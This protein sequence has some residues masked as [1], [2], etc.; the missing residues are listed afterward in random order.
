MISKRNRVERE[1]RKAVYTYMHLSRGADGRRF[2]PLGCVRASAFPNGKKS[3]PRS[4][5]NPLLYSYHSQGIPS[6]GSREPLLSL[7]KRYRK[8]VDSDVKYKGF[9]KSPYLLSLYI[10]MHNYSSC[11]LKILHIIC[12]HTIVYVI[13]I[14]FNFLLIARRFKS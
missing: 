2:S 13:Y 9:R 6:R 10:H 11:S 12:K 8:R 1:R 4:A 5:H 7:T 14:Y 3:F